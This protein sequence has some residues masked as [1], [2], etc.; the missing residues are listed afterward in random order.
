[1]IKAVGYR[2]LIE[3]DEAEEIDPVFKAAKAAGLHFADTDERKMRG[4]GVDRGTVLQVGSDAYK[5]MNSPWCKVGDYVAVAKY[6][7]KL[8]EHDNKR[9][10]VVNDDDVIAVIKE[11]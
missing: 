8:V 7:G 5:E 3:L 9:L 6:S 10:Y 4:S 2:L 11:A 1:V